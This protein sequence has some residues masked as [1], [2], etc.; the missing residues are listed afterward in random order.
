MDVSLDVN[1]LIVRNF[2]IQL[3]ALYLNLTRETSY[4][5]KPTTC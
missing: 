4:M 1:D 3:G 2:C 5:F